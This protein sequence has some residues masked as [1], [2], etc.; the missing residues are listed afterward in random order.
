M[1]RLYDLIVFDWDG[2]L[3]DSPRAIVACIQAACRDLG[4][5]PPDDHR[6]RHV[7][8]LGLHDAL[9]T[10]LPQLAP[11]EYF[12]VAER[13]RHHFL[14]IDEQLNLFAGA[15]ELI[16]KLHA[17]GLLL[18]VATGKSRRGLE[19]ALA[20][21]GLGEFFHGTR[22]ADET[23]PKPHPAMLEEIM[24]ELG[25][26]AERTLMVGD[27]TH[28]LLMARNARVDALAVSFGA[29]SRQSLLAEQPRICVDSFEELDRW[30]TSQI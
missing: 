24:A 29:H 13:Y 21:S 4:I 18:G 3:L 22:C 6:A 27:T 23:H 15:S 16:E 19:R 10:A 8:G 1:S 2:T 28:D 26:G 14:S 5:E 7:I 25:V 11:S 30:L 12:R 20:T 9:S 17:Y